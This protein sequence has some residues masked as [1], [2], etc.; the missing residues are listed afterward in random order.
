MFRETDDSVTEAFEDSHMRLP[1]H[2]FSAESVVDVNLKRLFTSNILN[3]MYMNIQG[4]LD[5]FLIDTNLHEV[6]G[7]KDG[8]YLT[9]DSDS[10]SRRFV[11][12]KKFRIYNQDTCRATCNYLRVTANV[13]EY[14]GPW[15][16]AVK[17]D[18]CQM[19]GGVEVLVKSTNRDGEHV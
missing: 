1:L 3:F 8:V 4:L 9:R 2:G 11:I 17:V 12:I 15:I 10:S 13:H 16:V 5:L 14:P 6:A 19:Q 18:M 7:Y